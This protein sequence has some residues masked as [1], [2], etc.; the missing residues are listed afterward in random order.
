MPPPH[1]CLTRMDAKEEMLGLLSR[2]WVKLQDL[3]NASPVELGA[4]FI[5]LTFI[6][7]F[8][9]SNLYLLLVELLMMLFLFTPAQ[10][11]SCSWTCW[12]AWAVAVARQRRRDQL[13]EQKCFAAQVNSAWWNTSSRVTVVKLTDI[14]DISTSNL[15]QGVFS[16]PKGA[17][18]LNNKAPD[19]HSGKTWLAAIHTCYS[20]QVFRRIDIPWSIPACAF[21]EKHH[22]HHPPSQPPHP[23]KEDALP[24]Y[25]IFN[26]VGKMEYEPNKCVE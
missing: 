15:T 2:L 22:H 10:W 17:Q 7:E 18:P 21:T 1:F 24:M 19:N 4:F 9:I 6:C 12:P 20:F 5:L 8:P 13:F 11:W 26:Y 23:P 14:C 25:N 3:P 16:D